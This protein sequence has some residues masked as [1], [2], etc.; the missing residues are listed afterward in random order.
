MAFGTTAM[1]GRPWDEAQVRVFGPSSFLVQLLRWKTSKIHLDLSSAF[2]GG[3]HT[4]LLQT[5]C[6]AKTL[7]QGHQK[8]LRFRRM[9]WSGTTDGYPTG[10]VER[11]LE[12]SRWSGG[13]S[14]CAECSMAAGPGGSGRL[15]SRHSC[16]LAK[17]INVLERS[18][19]AS[20]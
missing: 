17:R 18:C 5:R 1:S 8:H 11:R 19:R 6:F 4:L 2:L 12:R 9:F 10:T 20:R 13:F 7:K 14:S 3:L 16:L 15:R